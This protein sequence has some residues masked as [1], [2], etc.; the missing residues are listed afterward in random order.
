[1]SFPVSAQ[2]GA[3]AGGSRRFTTGEISRQAR[4]RLGAGAASAALTAAVLTLTAPAGT[5]ASAAAAPVAARAYGVTAL[6]LRAM[7]VGRIAFGRDRHH[8]LTVRAVMF[9]LTPGSAHSVDLWV[10]GRSRVIRFGP[11]TANSVGQA[12]ST[13]SSNFMGRWRP[14]SRL[15]IRMGV[16]RS[17]VDREPVAQTRR[18]HHAGRHAHRLIA[19]EVSR[20]GVRYGTP[21]GGATLAY[22]PSGHTLTVTVHARG[23]TPGPHAAHLH[24]GSCMSQG[25]VKYMLRDLVANRRGRIVHAVRVFTN[26][27]TPVPPHS[28]YLNIHQGNSSDILSNGQPSIF[29][30][31]LLCANIKR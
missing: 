6:T 21:R 20:K 13:L 30:R 29:F 28:W 22:N 9:G 18:L 23:V 31:P 15:L 7:P 10:P 24:V 17:R 16:G 14:G 27:R 5:S 2:R 19:V 11:L 4:I 1:V 12:A 3:R 25:P 26:V 8:H